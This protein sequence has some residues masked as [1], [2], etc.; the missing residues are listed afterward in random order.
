MIT[1]RQLRGIFAALPTPVQAD[2]TVHVDA[3]RTMVRRQIDGGTTGLVPIGGT[4]EYGALSV[5]QREA[6]V[7]AT[8]EASAGRLPVIAGILDPGYPDALAAGRRMAAAGADALMVITPYYTN[9]TPAGVRDYFLRYADESPLPIVLYDIPYRTRIA[10][11]PELHHVLSRHER[12]VGMKACNLDFYHF[13]HV[14]AGVSDDF[15]VLSGEDTLLPL[16][17]VAG[18]HGG[19]VVTA[20][21]LPR[22]WNRL[23]QLARDGHH[24]QALALHR[25]LMP[26]MDLAFAET[27]PGPLKAVLD[28]VGPPAP[29]L[30]PPLVRPAASV[31]QAL[32]TEVRELLAEFGE[33]P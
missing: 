21:L 32:R 6:M 19:I 18:A 13:L 11:A 26:M 2:G 24:D 14:V 23:H 15:A 33:T 22:A 10:M 31:E 9:P 25:R 16:H 17:L 30:L 3:V 27:N 12:I 7:R 1:S 4:G 20:T 28:L 5:A 8:A 29:D